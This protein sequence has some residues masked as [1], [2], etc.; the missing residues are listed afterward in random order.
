MSPRPLK[1]RF[2]R[3]LRKG[4]QQ[5]EGLGLQAEEGIERHLFGRLERLNMVRRFVITWVGLFVLLIA[6]LIWQLISLS[7]YYQTL[8]PVPGGIYSEG[9]QGAFTTANPMYATKPVDATVARLVFS[10]LFKYNEQNK[11]VGDLASDYSVDAAAKTY[12]VHLKPKLTWQDGAPLTSAD[13]VF[14][15]GAIQNPDARSPL[16]SG[17]QGVKVSA[18]DAHTVVFTL[19]NALVSF[20]YNLTNGIVPAHILSKVSAADLRTSDFN[21][22][23]PVGAGPFK[24]QALQVSGGNVTNA[25]EQI[26]LV[27]FENYAGGAPKL[28][29][30]VVQAYANNE[31]LIKTFKQG[32]LT[33]VAGLASVPA[34]VIKDKSVSR[35]NMLLTAGTYVFFKTSDGVLADAKVRQA[36]VSASD[37][38]KIVDGLGYT[39]RLVTEP[40]LQGQLGYDPASAQKTGNLAAAQSLL[41][42]AGWQAGKDGVRHKSGQPL[43]F[44]LSAIDTPENRMVLSELQDQWRPLGIRLNVQLQSSDDFNTTLTAHGYD[45]VLYGV[46]IGTDPD[47]FAYWDS[48]QASV[49]SA[50]RLNLS[51][52]KS[53]VADAALEGGRTRLDP[54]LRA[55]KYK[56][57]L[58]AWQQDAPALGLYQPRYL[59]LTHGKVYGLNDHAINTGT[60]RFTN[61]QNW[62]VH[63][64]KVTNK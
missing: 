52:Y 3:R 5:V 40:L 14:T 4:Q 57:F 17:W 60:D 9:I 22:V 42:Q 25:Q 10:G 63:T 27:P 7:G 46:S 54:A 31:Q 15:Y 19:P 12:T 58:Q 37:P 21:T 51:E 56:P 11:L 41:D 28:K 61:V 18:S 50:N 16:A 8:K 29:E 48:S 49:L 55:V 32:Q 35:H 33:A 24:W 44:E 39:T 43:Q 23:N 6:V 47:V 2:R 13:V 45:A 20:P 38:K 1:L 64:A 26:A 53:S 36:L 30:F 34:E 59:Y 62:M